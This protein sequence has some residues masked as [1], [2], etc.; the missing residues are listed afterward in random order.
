MVAVGLYQC[1]CREETK[2]WNDRHAQPHKNFSINL[3]RD[4]IYINQMHFLLFGRMT[5]WMPEKWHKFSTDCLEFYIP[6]LSAPASPL[7]TATGCDRQ[8]CW[9]SMENASFLLSNWNFPSKCTSVHNILM[10]DTWYSSMIA[11]ENLSPIAKV[12][13]LQVTIW[14]S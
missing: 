12:K 10:T 7:M 2:V 11:V 8:Y 5:S 6:S 13:D 4:E 9:S 14:R 1:F 3:F